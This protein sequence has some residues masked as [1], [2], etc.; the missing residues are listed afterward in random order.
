MGN[1][2]YLLMGLLFIAV[3]A[4]SGCVTPWSGSGSTGNGNQ[5]HNVQGVTNIALNGPGTLIIQQG[6][7]ESFSVEGS[8]SQKSNVD[9]LTSGNNL[10]ITNRNS[11]GEPLKFHLTVKNLESLTVT[12]AGEINATDLN[13]STLTLTSN[14]GTIS[15]AGK[16]N[17]LTA[18]INGLGTI[19]A[20]DLEAQTATINVNGDGKAN[21]NVVQTLKAV[22]NG[23]GSITYLGN[24]QVDQ[25]I[26]G[27][28]TVTPG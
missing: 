10:A 28:G 16:V 12:G 14:A 11:G 2:Y 17:I 22:I 19:N 7:N 27:Q 3:V 8:D 18:T 5:Q 23:V 25:Q 6:D 4:V 21:L 13:V 26:N 9:I 24:P 15:L 20:E 1:R